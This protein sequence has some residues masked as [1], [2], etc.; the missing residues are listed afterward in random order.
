MLQGGLG[1]M[2]GQAS[3]FVM[4]AP[5]KV[6]YGIKRYKDEV[7]RLY[8]VIEHALS[9]G[10]QWLAAGEYTIADIANFSW[11][12]VHFMAGKPLPSSVPLQKLPASLAQHAITAYH[13]C[14]PYRITYH[15]LE[16]ACLLTLKNDYVASPGPGLQE[17]MQLDLLLLE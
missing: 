11:I 5:Q 14:M 10:R 15:W 13:A 6:D 2:Q 9:D 1:P 7:K 16:E 12:Y 8:H 17:L 4:F 3:H